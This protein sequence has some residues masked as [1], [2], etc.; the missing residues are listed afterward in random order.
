MSIFPVKHTEWRCGGP[1]ASAFISRSNGLGSS[2]ASLC[3]A[4]YSTTQNKPN[5]EC[6]R[7]QNGKRTVTPGMPTEQNG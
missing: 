2:P 1:M 4:A 5:R 7:V 6:D 3:P